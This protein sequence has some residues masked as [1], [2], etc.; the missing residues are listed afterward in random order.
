LASE[1]LRP[2]HPNAQCRRLVVNY[3]CSVVGRDLQGSGLRFGNVRSSSRKKA[4]AALAPY[5]AGGALSVLFILALGV[6]LAV[7][8]AG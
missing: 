4:E 8:A 6:Y 5:S 1:T 7:A 3:V 2:R